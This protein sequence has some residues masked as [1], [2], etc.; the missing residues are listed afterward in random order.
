M[1]IK[2]EIVLYKIV[3]TQ[4]NDEKIITEV[5]SLDSAKEIKKEYSKLPDYCSGTL[6]I[7]QGEGKIR[8]ICG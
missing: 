8:R 6:T 7:E 3:F 2:E 4:G 1:I 5:E